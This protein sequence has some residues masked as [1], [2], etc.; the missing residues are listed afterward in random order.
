[1]ARQN[2]NT[3][4]IVARCP[5]CARWLRMVHVHG[6]GQCAFCGSNVEP[7]CAGA[8]GDEA[9]LAVG[10]PQPQGPLPLR[11]L[12]SELGDAQASVTHEALVNAVC[13]R[14]GCDLTEAC[15]RL[16]H[17]IDQGRLLRIENGVYRLP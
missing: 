10:P 13:R 2:G 17:E 6:H 16:L 1:M 7:C 8:A 9:E 4:P 12:F 5:A 3:S 11:A 14:E 15:E